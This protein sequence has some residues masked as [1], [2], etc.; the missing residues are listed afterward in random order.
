MTKPAPFA[1]PEELNAFVTATRA[2]MD[3]LGF[4][5]AAAP[6]AR[7]QDTAYTTGSEWLGDLGVA[8][9]EAEACGPLAPEIRERLARIRAAVRGAWPRR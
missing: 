1:S 2:R 9:R 3:E 6:L 4:A 5:A 7:V 8:A